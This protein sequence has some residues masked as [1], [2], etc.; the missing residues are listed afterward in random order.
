MSWLWATAEHGDTTR[1]R[2]DVPAGTVA[3]IDGGSRDRL[4]GRVYRAGRQVE[5]RAAVEF[6]ATAL[7]ATAAA[8]RGVPDAGRHVAVLGEGTLAWLIRIALPMQARAGRVHGA[9][10]VADDVQVVVDTTGSADV[11]SQAVRSLPRLGLLILAAPP[12]S[13]EI[14][15]ATY[16]DI[17]VRG[18]TLVGVPWADSPAGS[19][20]GPAD[21]AMWTA[22]VLANIVRALPDQPMPR[23]SLFAL[24]GVRRS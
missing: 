6:A 7:A 17:H 2:A 19:A 4:W 14:V 13:A 5:Q 15:L 24:E 16:K 22:A 9:P 8:V 20:T 23:G 11:L 3:F 1:L 12:D 18:L 21:L 10:T